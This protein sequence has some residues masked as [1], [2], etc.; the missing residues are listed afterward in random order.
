MRSPTRRNRNI[1]TSKQGH[2]QENEL[3]IPP[4]AIES[5]S[6]FERLGKHQIVK[7]IINN[8]TFRFLIEETRKTSFHACTVDD[9]EKIIKHIPKEDYGDL[10]L[11]ILRQP[12]RKEENLNPAWGRLI[13][14]YEY[15]NDY[16]PAII[17]EATDL[18]RKLRW[19]KKLSIEAQ[20]EL[21]RLKND[22]H[23]IVIGKRFFETKYTM[24]NIRNTQL[25]RTLLHEFGHYAHYQNIVLKPL[26]GLK[27]ILDKLDLQI[28]KNDTATTNELFSE[29]ESTFDDY[30]MRIERN[31]NKYFSIISTEKE[32]YAHNYAERL[33]AKLLEKNNIPFDK[34]IDEQKITS[35]KLYIGDFVKL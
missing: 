19:G 12:T 28:D 25:Y 16:F 15:E 10:E 1:G 34:I 6:F 8:H 32:T 9:I 2:G 35:E 20:K 24:E 4:P 13:Y 23:K 27:S 30:H 22:G 33:K 11:I 7:R 21:E 18:E 31:E 17:I 29:W 5:K 3:I 26:E 14:S